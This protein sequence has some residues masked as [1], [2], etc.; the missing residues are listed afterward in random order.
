MWAARMRLTKEVVV[1][2]GGVGSRVTVAVE[3]DDTSDGLDSCKMAIG[4]TGF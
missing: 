1:V 3:R 2:Y 4:G